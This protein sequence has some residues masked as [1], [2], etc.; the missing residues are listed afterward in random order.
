LPIAVMWVL[1]PVPFA[2]RVRRRAVRK[3]AQAEY[4][5]QNPEAPS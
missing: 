1:L 5:A 2:A 4:E 3:R